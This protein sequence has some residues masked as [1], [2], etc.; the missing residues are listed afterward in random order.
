MTPFA[1]YIPIGPA[2]T[3]VIRAVD[4]INSLCA[5]EPSIPWIVLVDD[6]RDHRSLGRCLHVPS[7][8][9]LIIL[10]HPR[11]TGHLD[12]R[13][14]LCVADLVALDYIWKNL[15]ADFVLKIDTDA[16][17]IAP[18]SQKI[19]QK[20]R[21]NRDAG[22]LGLLGDS[23]HRQVRSFHSDRQVMRT[24]GS[25]LLVTERLKT[26]RPDAIAQ[27]E[28][29]QIKTEEQRRNLVR[30]CEQISP[31]VEMDFKGEHCQGGAY[32]VS[33]ETIGRMFDRGFLEDPLL[34]MS[35]PMGEDA[36]MG[37]YC[38]LVKLKS[39]DF[40]QHHDPFGIQARGLAY[41][42]ETLSQLGYSI[43]HSVKNDLQYSEAE[44]RQFFRLKR[45]QVMS[46]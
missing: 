27:L 16:L 34:W 40:S 38:A 8:C 35:I 31:I 1:A 6:S 43:I 26:H 19:A 23:C 36:M 5:Y 20:F 2:E 13:G 17:V 44:I 15:S 11:Q 41:A 9:R 12:S 39:I 3:E 30:V 21:Q 46:A 33:R 28:A 45:S 7:T 25:A 22:I 10:P 32:A 29:L 18:F 24:I 4:L 37:I 42:P 14:G